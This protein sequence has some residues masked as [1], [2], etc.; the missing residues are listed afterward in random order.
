MAKRSR[1]SKKGGDW[2]SPSTWKP[3]WKWGETG[4]SNPVVSEEIQP[5]T[6]TQTIPETPVTDTTSTTNYGARRRTHKA[7]KRGTKKTRSGKKSN[8]H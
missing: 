8:R 2:L 7:G 5:T 1:T 3:F 4:E 6:T